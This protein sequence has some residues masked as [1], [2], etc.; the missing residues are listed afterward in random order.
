M[1][2]LLRYLFFQIPG[3]AIGIAIALG[4]VHWN[5]IPSWV[6]ALGLFGLALKD[7]AFYPLLRSAYETRVKSGS[8]ALVGKK[9]IAQDDLAPEGYIR[10]NLELW[11]AVS[12]SDGAM[13]AS[14]T[15][16]EVVGAEG[17][18]LIVRTA[19]RRDSSL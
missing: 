14:G 7:L 17:M 3:W 18:K 4:L 2:T 15:E 11:R 19:G 10:I 6:A 9:G 5:V 13:I 1:P 12:D 8:A 16:V